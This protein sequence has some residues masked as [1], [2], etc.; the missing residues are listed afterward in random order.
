MKKYLSLALIVTFALQATVKLT[1]DCFKR[2]A[3]TNFE[4]K[5]VR[6][7]TML[8]REKI[9]SSQ[10]GLAQVFANLQNIN[11][12]DVISNEKVMLIAQDIYF[13][14]CQEG[15]FERVAAKLAKNPNDVP[16]IEYVLRRYLYK[17]RRDIY[18]KYCCK[19]AEFP[20]ERRDD[21]TWLN[22]DNPELFLLNQG[23]I[24]AHDSRDYIL[25]VNLVF[26]LIGQEFQDLIF[27][28]K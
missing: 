17:M 23:K 9:D 18:K 2:N 20:R 24:F 15:I 19:N 25:A 22:I 10:P 7:Q 28:Y 11:F 3:I 16:S 12:A 4:N 5:F 21:M 27:Q 26:S 1:P 6:V 8:D 13:S 14:W